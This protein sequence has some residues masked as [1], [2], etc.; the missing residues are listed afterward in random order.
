MHRC[1]NSEHIK[2]HLY[3]GRGIE[4]WKDWHDK[5]LFFAFMGERPDDHTVDRIDPDWHYEPGNVRWATQAQQQRNRRNNTFNEE[6]VRE[7]KRL[8]ADGKTCRE[9]ERHYEY[10]YKYS[11]LWDIIN[12]RTWGDI[13]V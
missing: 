3:G 13:S 12:G 4:V 7:V 8:V 10:K 9:I 5:H 6:L 1:Y 2:F 11:A